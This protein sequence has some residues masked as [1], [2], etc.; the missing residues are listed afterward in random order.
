MYST[1]FINERTAIMEGL[2]G[3]LEGKDIIHNCKGDLSYT[4]EYLLRHTDSEEIIEDIIQ[5]CEE[6]GGYC[7]CEVFMNV[8][9]MGDYVWIQDPVN[10]KMM[11][12]AG[13]IA[14]G[15]ASRTLEALE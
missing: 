3:Y 9:R 4:K 15:K 10:M 12:D 13:M 2:F 11:K 1:M 14:Y 8:P 7:D 5:Y 6:N